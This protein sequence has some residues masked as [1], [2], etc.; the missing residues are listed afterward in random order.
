MLTIIETVVEYGF[1]LERLQNSE[2]CC[3]FWKS[4]FEGAEKGLEEL[5]SKVTELTGDVRNK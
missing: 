4:T 1:K 2:Q 5:K 3:Q